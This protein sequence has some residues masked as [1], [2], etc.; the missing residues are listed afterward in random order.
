MNFQKALYFKIKE[1]VPNLYYGNA[2][3]QEPPYAVMQMVTDP[4]QPF[5]MCDDQTTA[6][7]CRLQ[8]SYAGN[9]GQGDAED[10]LETIRN[11][12]VA[13][14]GNITYS[15]V[16]FEV[17]QNITEGIRQFSPSLNTWDAIF[18]TRLSWRK[19]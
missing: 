4:A 7:D 3:S 15:G 13:I 9:K 11:V 8:F 5:V 1:S 10:E 16:T 2:N 14:I 12:V 19:L 18:E 17:W 6:G